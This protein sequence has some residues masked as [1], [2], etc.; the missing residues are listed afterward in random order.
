MSDTTVGLIIALIGIL[1][2]VGA[3]LNWRI[4]THSGK[5]LNMIF[6]DR[7]ARIIAFLVGLFLFALGV[8]QILGMNWLGE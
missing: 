6:G 4:V 8:G 1:T 2:M 3:A 5:L 7:I